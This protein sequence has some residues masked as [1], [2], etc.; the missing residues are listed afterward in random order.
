MD[1]Q[2]IILTLGAALITGLTSIVGNILVVRS[3][4]RKSV[5]ENKEQKEKEFMSTRI[6]A[7]ESILSIL[8]EINEN[9]NEHDLANKCAQ[10]E[11]KWLSN[12][13]YISININRRLHF[14]TEHL[15]SK[16]TNNIKFDIR[17]IRDMVKQEIDEYYNIKDKDNL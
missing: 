14:L 13:P 17:L 3:N 4:L 5:L 15:E 7:Y 12:Y 1:W 16:N 2:V 10:L 9:L 6:N 8:R 11:S